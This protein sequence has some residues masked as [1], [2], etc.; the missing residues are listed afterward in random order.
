MLMGIRPLLMQSLMTDPPLKAFWSDRHVAKVDPGR[1]VVEHIDDV[2]YLAF[3]LLRNAGAGSCSVHGWYV[4]PTLQRRR[5]GRASMSSAAKASISTCRQEAWVCGS[6]PYAAA[7][8][9]FLAMAKT[10]ADREPVRDRRAL[11]RSG[12]RPAQHQPLHRCCPTATT[13]GTRVGATLAG[14]PSCAACGGD[15][16]VDRHARTSFCTSSRLVS[17]RVRGAPRGSRAPSRRVMPRSR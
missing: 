8:E 2:I 3:G 6:P 5:P 4:W 1:A 16:A 9:I 15:D 11:R 17:L 14:R 7:G 10:V 13:P 12:G